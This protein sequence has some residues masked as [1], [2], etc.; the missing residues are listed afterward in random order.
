MTTSGRVID[1]VWQ[2]FEQDPGAKRAPTPTQL[3]RRQR[4]LR[5]MRQGLFVQ[6]ETILAADNRA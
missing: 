1:P 6:V 3:Q 5:E 2:A 4:G